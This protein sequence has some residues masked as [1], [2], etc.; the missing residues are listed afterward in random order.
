MKITPLAVTTL[1]LLA[2]APAWL[3]AQNPVYTS[4]EGTIL[5]LNL[6]YGTQL[7]GGDLSDRFGVNINTGIGL[8][9]FSNSNWMLELEGQ[10]LFGNRVK[11]DV[12]APLRSPEGYIFADD[13]GPADITLRERGWW[14][15]LSAGK[16]IALHPDNPRSGLRISVGAGLL[17]HKIRIQNDPQA[18]VP[19]LT[20]EYRKGYDRLSNGLALKQFIGYQ[21]FSL[22][23]R[24]NFFAGIELIQGFTASRRS[25]NIDEMA[26]EEGSRLDLLFGFRAGWVLPFYL[27]EKGETI[28]Y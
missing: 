14:L 20:T 21:H 6:S 28:Y 1:L 25:W 24:I 13:G 15:G 18:F 16:L 10:Y 19:A 17:E 9:L 5:A 26:R 8:Q 7:P 4:N 11:A 27:G 2:T 22:N 12:L 23:R 3:R